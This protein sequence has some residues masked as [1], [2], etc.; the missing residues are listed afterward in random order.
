MKTKVIIKVKNKD[1][2]KCETY[3]KSKFTKK[4]FPSVRRVTSLLELMHFNICELNG[5]FT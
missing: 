5:I 3:I 1:F 4:S 2:D